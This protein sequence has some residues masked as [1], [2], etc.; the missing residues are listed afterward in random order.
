[1]S[2]FS[3]VFDTTKQNQHSNSDI[4]IE[5]DL[6]DNNSSR[7]DA[8]AW[9]MSNK[10]GDD[11]KIENYPYHPNNPE[12][13]MCSAIWYKDESKLK[14]D[15]LEGLRLRGMSPYN[16]DHGIV[17]MGWRH[18]CIIQ[19]FYTLT[20]LRTVTNGYKSSGEFVQGFLS[21]R[22]RFLTR[23]QAGAMAFLTGQTDILHKSL[24]SEDLY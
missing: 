21:S 22:N 11:G 2:S 14:L 4:T 24:T 1:M 16:T 18:A 10:I 6:N 23:S 15:D 12:R 19:Q 8:V 13:V 7:S 20:G 17:L 3:R 9:A 5:L